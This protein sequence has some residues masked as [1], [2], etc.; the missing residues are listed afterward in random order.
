MHNTPRGGTLCGPPTRKTTATVTFNHF[1][2]DGVDF[3]R[4]NK[5]DRMFDSILTNPGAVIGMF[6]FLAI[7]VVVTYT[8][9]G[10][11]GGGSACPTELHRRMDGS[12]ELRPT[13]QTFTDMNAFQQWWHAPGGQAAS[14]CPLPLLTGAREVPVLAGPSGNEQTYA[15]TPIYKVDDYELSRIVGYERDGHMI[16]PRENYN[17]ILEQRTF[18][19]ADR[20]MTSDERRGKY[21]GLREGF[22]ANGELKTATVRS[23][24]SSRGTS[25]GFTANGELKT[26]T[27]RSG[28]SSLG[29]M[30]VGSTR[31][32]FVGSPA[33]AMDAAR[34]AAARYGE[35]RSQGDDDIDCKISR[36]AREVAAMVGRAYESDPN[37][38]PVVTKV[39]ANHWEVNELKP[40]RRYGEIDETVEERVV[41][42][43]NDAVDVKFRFRE[44]PVVEDAIDPYFGGLGGL[45]FASDRYSNDP[46]MGPV[47]GM[48]RMFGPTFDHKK[49]Y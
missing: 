47:P 14:G 34:E 8:M 40:R 48:E 21:Q 3:L 43:N 9:T 30:A 17:L 16:M 24:Y 11:G 42:T 15:K 32:G 23:G 45:P 35:R 1:S 31:E 12:L 28:Y 5:R 20:P 18:D 49:W 41:D 22:T 29:K 36:E 13:G 39:G 6:V 33:G 25:E 27:V 10:G 38:E 7:L 44:K 2:N 4:P 19:W 46:F 26:A 37:W